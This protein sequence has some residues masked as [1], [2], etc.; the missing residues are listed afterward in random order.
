MI[1]TT[2][3]FNI[4]LTANEIRF[5]TWLVVHAYVRNTHIAD[6]S[7]VNRSDAA[8]AG[9]GPTL[10]NKKMSIAAMEHGFDLEVEKY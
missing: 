10:I 1:D 4:K 7:F 2:T 5:I 3:T 6:D 9:F 8:A